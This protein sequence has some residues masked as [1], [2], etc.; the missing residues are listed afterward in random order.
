MLKVFAKF[1]E[2]LKEDGLIAEDANVNSSALT[3]DLAKNKINEI[4][5]DTS[6]PY[7]NS[8]HPSHRAATEEMRKLYGFANPDLAQPL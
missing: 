6:H 3:P 8:Q 4:R 5:G 2:V 7:H 1:G